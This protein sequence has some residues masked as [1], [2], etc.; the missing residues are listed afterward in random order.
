MMK[1]KLFVMLS[2]VMLAACAPAAAPPPASK[3]T[4]LPAQPASAPAPVLNIRPEQI[5]LSTTNLP[6]GWQAFHVPAVPFDGQ[7][8]GMPEHIEILFGTG[9]PQYWSVADPI[10]YIVPVAAYRQMADEARNPV[11]GQA[12]DKIE[13]IIYALDSP[14]PASGLSFLPIEAIVGQNDLTVQADRVAAVTEESASRNGYRFVGHFAQSPQPASNQGLR[15]VYLGF[16]NDA[17][18]LVIL[19]YPVKTSALPDSGDQIQSA[20]RNMFSANPQAYL[21]QQIDRLNPL[22]G[23]AWTPDLAQLDALIASLRIERLPA[24][25]LYGDWTIAAEAKSDGVE[26]PNAN[27]EKYRVTFNADDT[28]TYTADCNSG[29]G[30]FTVRGGMAGQVQV[31]P[32]PGTQNSCSVDSASS[33]LM[34]ALFAAQEYSIRAGGSQMHLT[35][36]ADRGYLVL[37]RQR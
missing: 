21:K 8:P 36:P 9:D 31:Q 20:D 19:L 15:Y 33:R 16:T 12:L 24:S 10:M 37:N 3:P 25:G 27:P 35:Q 26:Q 1:V 11:V 17:Q 4:E 22:P 32:G 13:S 28:L 18:Y 14:L 34:D 6:H 5:G 23:S 2:V 7:K 29:S 30:R